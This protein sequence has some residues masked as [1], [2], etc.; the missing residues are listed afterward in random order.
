MGKK[1]EL[2]AQLK[3]VFYLWI[4]ITFPSTL[5][6][7]KPIHDFFFFFKLE[8]PRKIIISKM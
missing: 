6:N 3:H 7:Q 8:E 5:D 4:S 2:I 1:F